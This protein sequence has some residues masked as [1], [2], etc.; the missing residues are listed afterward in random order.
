M[1][2]QTAKGISL[3]FATAVIS[4]FAIFVNKFGVAGF[5]PYLY[6]FLKN[7]LVAG[8]LVALLLGIKEFSFLKKLK[9]KDWFL[10]TTIG[11]IGGAIPFLLF[12]KGLSMTLAASG[13]F[14]HKTMFIYVAVL[15]V[16]F[17]KEKISNRLLIAGVLLLM[18]NLYF[19]K[20]LPV[21]L[22]VGDLLVFA[23]TLFWATEN[24][25]S[26]HALKTLSPRVVAFGR[27]GIGSV[28]IALFLLFTGGF[29][30]VSSL[31]TLH[32]Q[33]V[34]ISGVILFGYVI[35]WYTGLKYINVSTATIILLLGS[36]ITSFLVFIFQG[37]GF[38]LHQLIGAALL[39]FGVG[40]AVGLRV[41]WETLRKLPRVVYALRT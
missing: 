18:G 34:L 6:T 4:G 24:V 33:W 38:S 2:N 20:F 27:M 29:S 7:A 9:K 30:T 15:A 37:Q 8:F 1:N 41:I 28:F 21:G 26:K 10:L 13:S 31:T 16:V 14:I 23:A 3:V 17:L 5:D 36:P 32:W 22:Q 11:L 35:T 39:V 12:F 40:I 19:L 25:I